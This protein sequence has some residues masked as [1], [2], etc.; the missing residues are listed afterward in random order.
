MKE[1]LPASLRPRLRPGCLLQPLATGWAL[2]HRVASRTV[3][4]DDAGHAALA[5]LDGQQTV[6]DLVFFWCR[7]HQTID[8]EPFLRLLTELWEAG[9]LDP[10]TPG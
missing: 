7:E 8:V 10:E 1:A 3:V 5:W 4:L 6:E 9:L 2:R